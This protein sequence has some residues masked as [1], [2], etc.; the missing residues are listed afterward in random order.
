MNAVIIAVLVMIG[1]SLARIHVVVALI[2]G[3]A[4]GGL[5]A[6]LGVEGTLAAFSEGLGSNALIAL[7]YG[8][9][10]AFA[11]AVSYTG[12]PKLMINAALKVLSTKEDTRRR[13]LM[14]VLILLVIVFIS[15]L[16]QNL[17]PV[18]IAFIPLLIPPMLQVFNELYLDRRAAAS[19]LTFGL[20]APY[21]L[22]PAGYGAIYHQTIQENM[23][24]SGMSIPFE[25][26]QD[27]LIIPVAGMVVGLFIA[28][29]FS[30]R[31]PRTY[32]DRPL[33]VEEEES[34]Q[35]STF[36]IACAVLSIVVVLVV[37]VQTDSMIAGAFSGLLLLYIYF[38]VLRITSGFTLSDADDILTNG[39]KMLAFIG[40]V[41]ITAG[42][43]AEVIRE[44]GHVDSLVNTAAQWVDGR[45]GLAAAVMLIIGLFITMGIGSSFATVPIL[46]AV[47]V[48]LGESLG[49][50][51]L[52][53][54]SL[55][56]TAGALG[57]AGSPASDST[58]GPTAGL[59]A[60]G[61]HN[62]I[63]DTVVPTFIHYNI[64]LLIFG[65]IA[66]MIL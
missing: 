51:M 9:L 6:G 50:S 31:K 39:M 8:L 40:F 20:K 56:G 63:W 32:E 27:A 25:A 46:A 29:F 44:T 22:I 54:I 37:Q 13:G 45:M 47:F 30:Y 55:I 2:A 17:V 41:M 33:A 48:P 34:A 66:A 4:A 64:P 23:E 3:A 16:S 24:A 49:F 21:M 60:D 26:V 14:K 42:G 15:S 59:N 12:L 18:H 36:G 5:T 52:A 10:G 53:I 35:F 28:L 43:F 58:L 38:I 61:Q 65:W 1:L 11:V 62:H 19:A 7:S 57:D